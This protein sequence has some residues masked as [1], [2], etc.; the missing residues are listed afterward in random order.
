MHGGATEK[1]RRVTTI[2]KR[3]LPEV[4]LKV[5]ICHESKDTELR[6]WIKEKQLST[7]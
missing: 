5:L 7:G 6:L 3:S 1:E 4:R 2:N